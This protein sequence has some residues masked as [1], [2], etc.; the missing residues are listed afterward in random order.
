M[1][2]YFKSNIIFS[3]EGNI[4]SGK[5]TYVKYLENF[6]N[7]KKKYFNNCEESNWNTIDNYQ[8]Y[9]FLQEP[10]KLWEEIT[11]ENNIPILTKF[12]ENTKKYSFQ[13]QMMAYISRLSILK[14]AINTNPNKKIISE[15]SLD[16]DKFVFEKML[17]DGGMIEEIE[18]KIYNKWFY[19]FQKESRIN[20]I[21]YIKT[22][23][24]ICYERVIKRNREGETIELDYLKNCHKYHE[25]WINNVNK[26]V[27]VIDGNKENDPDI[28]NKNVGET[29]NFIS[30]L[31]DEKKTNN[32][33][34]LI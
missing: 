12:Y 16:T 24:E 3:V 28:I 13:F 6:C 5:S 1:S 33:F 10:V 26:P 27:L 30:K 31:I 20:A 21:I 18:H 23:P 7:T 19:D 22:E 2:E 29:T 4:G 11:D 25:K 32:N 15:R 34:S 17:Y 14:E 9:I 8:N